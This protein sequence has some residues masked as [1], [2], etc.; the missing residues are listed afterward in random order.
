MALSQSQPETTRVDRIQPIAPTPASEPA[1]VAE[2]LALISDW[3]GGVVETHSVELGRLHDELRTL[4]VQRERSY[5]E[6][7]RLRMLVR[8]FVADRERIQRDLQ[9]MA[10]ELHNE[11]DRANQEASQRVKLNDEL[12]RLSDRLVSES[13]RL[14]HERTART[15]AREEL[16]MVAE[17]RDAERLRAER[18]AQVAAL[19]WWQWRRK[20][21]LLKT[22]SVKA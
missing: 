11:R 20:R 12:R 19:P 1:T 3:V 17:E 14:E 21:A 9:R 5:G 2:A 18:L 8:S 16:M 22:L 15:C 7:L 13:E 10:D 4:D 6:A